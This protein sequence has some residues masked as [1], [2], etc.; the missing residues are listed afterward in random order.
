MCKSTNTILSIWWTTMT[1]ASIYTCMIHVLQL[2]R[3]HH[4]YCTKYTKA[5]HLLHLLIRAIYIFWTCK[6]HKMYSGDTHTVYK[7]HKNDRGMKTLLGI[8]NCNSKWQSDFW[9]VVVCKTL[10]LVL[11]TIFLLFLRV[12]RL[13]SYWW[14][15]CLESDCTICCSPIDS[16][17]LIIYTVEAPTPSIS[18]F[19]WWTTNSGYTLGR[20]FALQWLQVTCYFRFPCT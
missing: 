9:F 4:N 17:M 3:H 18:T 7:F 11:L 12:S 15:K 10:T 20:C 19:D 8:Y 13:I 14:Q 2:K 16:I 5:W 6:E 1:P